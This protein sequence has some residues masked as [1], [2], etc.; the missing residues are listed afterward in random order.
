MKFFSRKVIAS[1]SAGA[2]IQCIITIAPFDGGG[3][4]GGGGDFNDKSQFY[5]D[6]HVFQLVAH[7]LYSVHESIQL[8]HCLEV[9]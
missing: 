4:G 8:S 2:Y 1:L 6:L 5:T 3:G 7:S 9:R